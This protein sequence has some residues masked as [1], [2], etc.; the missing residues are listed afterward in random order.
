MKIRDVKVLNE[1]VFIKY[2]AV[3]P[4]GVIEERTCKGEGVPTHPFKKALDALTPHFI[5]VM[6]FKK[7]RKYEVYGMSLKYHKEHARY[8]VTLKGKR[9][10]EIINGSRAFAAPEMHQPH[11]NNEDSVL[12]MS[13]KMNDDV[14]E[15]INQVKGYVDGRRLQT[16]ASLDGKVEVKKKEKQTNAFDKKTQAA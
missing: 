7:D 14:R 9:Y 6:E 4:D 5:Q 16:K 3:G 2:E 12:P 8:A 15:F 11:P 1:Q 13:K 10:F